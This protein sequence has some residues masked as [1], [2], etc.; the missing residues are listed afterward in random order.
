MLA[1]LAARHMFLVSGTFP[2]CQRSSHFKTEHHRSHCPTVGLYSMAQLLNRV[3]T[4]SEWVMNSPSSVSHLSC[5][6]RAVSADVDLHCFS[7]CVSLACIL[8]LVTSLVMD[9]QYL[10]QIRVILQ[11]RLWEKGRAMVGY[12]PPKREAAD[13]SSRNTLWSP[14]PYQ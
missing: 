2:S 10:W 7:I 13:I 14:T 5:C 1:R 3:Q 8:C 4:F 9:A 11:V 12:L 6:R